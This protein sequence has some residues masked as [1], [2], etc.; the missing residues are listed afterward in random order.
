MRGI[1]EKFGDKIVNECLD[2]LDVYLERA[3]ETKEILVVSK[4]IL[5]MVESAPN[6]LLTDLRNRFIA[7]V[8]SNLSHENQEIRNMSA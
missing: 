5:N 6:K 4:T 8:D 1:A 2:I 7:I 3:T